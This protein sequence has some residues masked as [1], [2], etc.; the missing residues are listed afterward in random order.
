MQ[1]LDVQSTEVGHV[2]RR[3]S[4]VPPAL[5]PPA[6]A[7]GLAL[8]AA[9]LGWRGVDLPAQIYRAGL[10]HRNG[11]TLW[12]SQWYG[13]HW[14]FDYSVVFPPLAGIFGVQAVGVVSAALAAWSF[15]RLA[16]GHFG[17]S[18]RFGSL[19]F[20]LGTVVAV[21][22]GQL[23]FLL[24]EA[25]A[26]AAGLAAV[27]KRWPLAL[28][29]ALATSLASPLAGAFLGL[30]AL[31]WLFTTWPTHRLG[32]ALLVVCV[33]LPVA[34]TAVLF[35]GQG[36]FPYP[37]A[38]FMWEA[39]IGLGVWA[40]MPKGERGLRTALR[41]YVLAAAASFVL[42]TPVGGN[43][44]RLG[45]C[46][47]LPLAACVLWP[48]RRWLLVLVAVPLVFWQW[49]PAW[50][51][52]ADN[53][54]DPSSH[55]AYYQPLLAF[56]AQHAAPAARVEVVPTR[57]HWEAAYV[58]PAVALARG[59][60]RQL[61]I[62]DNSLFY[63]PGAL[64][65]DTYRSWLLNSGVRYVALPDAP[66]DYA[67]TDE[68]ELL[69]AGVPGLALVWH[70]THWQVFDLTAAQ[71]IVQGPAQLVTLDGGRVVLD[72]TAPGPI[73][74]RVR[75]SSRW[76][77]AEGSACLSPGADGWTI[78]TVTSPGQVRLQLRLVDGGPDTC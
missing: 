54:R 38:D 58:A 9:A 49:T 23:P 46:F 24:G 19:V 10:F 41:L 34:V 52:M 60:E 44:G 42:P 15:D 18:A 76:S 8:A 50:G 55:P 14:T 74:V 72:A 51:S 66:L 30:A 12:D 57:L 48:L 69:R 56:L 29:L 27:R 67:A 47:A 16:I 40:L 65:A 73:L 62:A 78:V 4:L 45:E 70:D 75:Y 33:G 37:A 59:W 22:I 1:P 26:L 35:P 25:L 7:A 20:A 32:T 71:G 61:D 17:V 21:A 5:W 3:W 68:A 77:V 64:D 13:G 31:A 28:L 36:V 6:L 39:A 11:L 63:T 43:I 2:S 53:G